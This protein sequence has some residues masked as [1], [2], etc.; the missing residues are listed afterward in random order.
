MSLGDK[1]MDKMDKEERDKI[2][3]FKNRN[4]N[5]EKRKEYDNI[6][7]FLIMKKN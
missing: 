1:I 6:L 7:G 3:S 2:P 4:G 5:F